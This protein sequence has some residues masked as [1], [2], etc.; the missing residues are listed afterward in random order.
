MG[1]R[2]GESCRGN[3]GA[4][5]GYLAIGGVTIVGARAGESSRGNNGAWPGYHATKEAWSADTREGAATESGSI[6]V[7][8]YKY[9]TPYA[10]AEVTES[11]PAMTATPSVTRLTV[12]E[13]NV[14]ALY[15]CKVI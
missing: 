1:A 5:P 11:S 3:N 8:D 14:V 2:A 7:L 6:D 15:T 9:I 13:I 12:R 10:P 4:W